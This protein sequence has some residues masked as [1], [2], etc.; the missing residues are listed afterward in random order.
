MRPWPAVGTVAVDP[1]QSTHPCRVRQSFAGSVSSSSTFQSTHPCRVRPIEREEVYY[2]VL[3]QSTHP[4]RVRLLR[5][6][7]PGAGLACFN[8]RTRVGCDLNNRLPV[9]L[10]PMFQSTHPCRVRLPAALGAPLPLV[11]QSTHPCR[12]RQWRDKQDMEV[13]VFQSTHPCRVRLSLTG[14]K[15]TSSIVSIHAPV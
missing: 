7:C 12:V 3:F 13:N 2:S 10:I 8:P 4:C 11:F 5:S 9:I 15:S 1:F 14:V 6:A